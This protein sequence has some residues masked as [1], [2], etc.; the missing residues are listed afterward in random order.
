MRDIALQFAD[1]RTAL[2]KLTFSIAADAPVGRGKQFVFHGQHGSRTLHDGF[3]C[4]KL[5]CAHAILDFAGGLGADVL[6]CHNATSCCEL[7]RSGKRLS[8]AD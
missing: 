3:V 1:S 2:S 4:P 5:A 8:R 6:I 7:R